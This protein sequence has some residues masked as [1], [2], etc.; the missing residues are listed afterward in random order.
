MKVG[1]VAANGRAGRRIVKRCVEEGFEVTAIVR[2]KN[3]TVAQN[4]LQ[5]DLFDLTVN[6]VK[7][8][9][10][11]VDAFGVWD[12]K[13]VEL[14]VSSMQHL[15]SILQKTNV[16]LIVVGGAGSLIA[17]LEMNIQL[18][19]TKDFPEDA[20]PVAKAMSVALDNLQIS[21]DLRWTYI[22]PAVNFKP[23]DES[24]GHYV[25]ITGDNLSFDKN[26]KSEISY[27]D[28]AHALV[29]EIKN[30]KYENQRISVR[31]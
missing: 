15:I 20:R 21:K 27:A 11:I 5:K 14:H 1:V 7:G 2:H 6:D 16:R 9:D 8:F 18:V 26:G 19:D 10:V 3:Q 28:Y 12:A 13:A 23:T 22:S 25:I 29:D 17:D 31:W 30:D 24:Q 4:V